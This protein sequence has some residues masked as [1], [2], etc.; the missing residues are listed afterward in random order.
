MIFVILSTAVFFAMNMGSTSFATCFAAPYGGGL[1][2]RNTSAL[3]FIVFVLLGALL[4]GKN[5]SVTLGKGLI[6]SE[7]I[8]ALALVIIFGCAGIS[9]F[10][11]NYFHI[12]QSTSLVTV[13]AIAG[14]GVRLNIL[15]IQTL[16]YL[17]PFWIVLP[18][19]SF[20]LTWLIAY[21]IYPPR[22]IN[23]WLYERL[24][25]HTGKL[26]VFVIIVSCYNAFSVGTNNVANVVGPVMG[27]R[28]GSLISYLGIFAL[29][30][31][32]GTLIFR[33]TL[34]LVSKEIVPLGLMTASV[35]SLVSGSCMILAS[36]FGVPQ[37]FVMLQ[38]GAIFAIS[39]LKEGS[40][41]TL[42]SPVLRKTLY[43]WAVNPLLTF[44]LS[45]G[46]A[47]IFLN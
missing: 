47:R 21:Y 34:K 33:N 36:I 20:F 4:L 19:L 24:I 28:E 46:L 26:K 7:S 5:V 37:S 14:V 44:A 10:V 3:L 41:I 27:F 25:N 35:I 43:T 1:L 15:N 30:Y 12:P 13:A 2:K 40:D 9:M 18:I 45:L 23:F 38:M 29:I 42:T 8:S 32:L 6:P 17:L 22:K 39:C 11:A 16:C 31:G